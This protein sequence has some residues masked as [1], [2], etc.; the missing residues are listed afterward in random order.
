MALFQRRPQTS[1]PVNYVTVGLNKTLLIVGLGNP[2]AEYN[3]TRHNVGFACLDA[4]VAA[5]IEQGDMQLWIAKNDLK[6]L[7]SSGQMGDTRVLAVKPTT[8]MNLSGEAVQAI[9]SFYRVQLEKTVVIH[10]ELDIDFGQIRMRTGGSAAGHNGVKSIT[11][12][13]GEGYGRIRIG[14]GPKHPAQIDSADFVLQKFNDDELT[15][16]AELTREVSAVLSEL[17]YGAE[18]QAETRSFLI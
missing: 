13:M 18:L 10:D 16:M 9:S 3:Q 2:G 1:N 6:C 15:H 11:Q 7:V 14:I 12:H 8:F 5:R 17:I 4:F